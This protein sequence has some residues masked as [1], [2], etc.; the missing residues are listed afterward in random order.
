MDNMF[1]FLLFLDISL[2][3]FCDETNGNVMV[4]ISGVACRKFL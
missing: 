3:Y 4:T 1:R 2:M